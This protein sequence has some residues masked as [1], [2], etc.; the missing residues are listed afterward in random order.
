ME[1]SLNDKSTDTRMN[2][3]SLTEKSVQPKSYFKLKMEV[4]KLVVWYEF[5]SEFISTWNELFNHTIHIV[6]FLPALFGI[7]DTKSGIS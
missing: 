5:G 7:F 6:Q 2:L 4:E 1:S 3:T